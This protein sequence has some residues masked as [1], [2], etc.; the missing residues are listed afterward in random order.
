ML[1]QALANIP[2]LV[3]EEGLPGAYVMPMPSLYR[4]YG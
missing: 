4:Y 1:I 3:D 2:N